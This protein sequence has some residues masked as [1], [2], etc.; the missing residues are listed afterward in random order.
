M[1]PVACYREFAPCEPLRECVTALFTCTAPA[2][3]SAGSRWPLGE[4]VFHEGEPFSSA[5]FADVHLSLVFSFGV[6]Y[7]IDGLWHPGSSCGCGHVIGPMTRYRSASPGDRIVQVGAFFR[8][9][10]AVAFVPVSTAELTDRVVAL[11]DL[12]GPQASGVEAKL[13]ECANDTGRIAVLEQALL[14]RIACSR[15]PARS[16]KAADLAQFV[17]DAGG[18]VGVERLAAQAGVSRQHLR[19][20][21]L[22]ETGVAPKLFA[23]LARFR[24]A[25][26]CASGRYLRDGAGWASDFG[27][28][29]QS[30]MIA[31][32]REFSGFTPA[33]LS[34]SRR[35]HPF[36]SPAKS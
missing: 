21:F 32:F 20:I 15:R 28:S 29:D 10:G 35:F 34:S 17:L 25:L 31:E 1:Q 6:S 5:L 24:A 13:A 19:R 33:A 16:V 3:L 7:R 23:R 22:E 4:T 30:H 8:P 27:Y 11:R 2:E 26:A 14:R 12:W 9:A 36:K 18:E